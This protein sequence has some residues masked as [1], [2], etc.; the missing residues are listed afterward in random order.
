LGATL[1]I[2]PTVKV[3]VEDERS[4][5]AAVFSSAC[6]N[7]LFP[8]SLNILSN[9]RLGKFFSNRVDFLFFLYQ[10]Y[11][12]L[13][14]VI[15]LK[16]RKWILNPYSIFHAK[17]SASFILPKVKALKSCEKLHVC[18]VYPQSL[19]SPQPV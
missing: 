1:T 5:S 17:I 11:A 15:I 16:K 2:I 10:K 12:T 14:T 4:R 18:F 9:C 6:S 3:G 8:L 19:V 7:G 13:P